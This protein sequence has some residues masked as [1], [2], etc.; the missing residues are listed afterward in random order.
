MVSSDFRIP[1][2]ATNGRIVI[3]AQLT[4]GLISGFKAE[5]GAV[6]FPGA[7]DSLRDAK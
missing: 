6:K 2:N 5:T 7:A 4:A 3:L 1:G